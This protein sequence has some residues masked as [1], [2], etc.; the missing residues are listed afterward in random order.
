MSRILAALGDAG[1]RTVCLTRL[2]PLFPFAFQN[3]GWADDPGALPELRAWFLPRGPRWE[4]ASLP[5]WGPRPGAGA[6]LATESFSWSAALTILGLLATFYLIRRVTRIANAAL[7]DEL[8]T[9]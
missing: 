4:P 7:K 6:T 2:S 5:I 1:V 8:P 3:F 9:D